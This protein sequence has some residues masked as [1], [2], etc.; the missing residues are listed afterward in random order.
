MAFLVD[1]P[2][3]E[4]ADPGRGEGRIKSI[5]D[6]VE[7]PRRTHVIKILNIGSAKRG[8]RLYFFVLFKRNLF[9]K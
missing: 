9:P 2:V 4:I 7:F 5:G 8:A 1:L 3:A 6:Q